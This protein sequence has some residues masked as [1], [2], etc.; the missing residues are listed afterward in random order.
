MEKDDYATF[1]IS[2]VILS[3]TGSAFMIYSYMT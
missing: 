1:I 2:A 3:S